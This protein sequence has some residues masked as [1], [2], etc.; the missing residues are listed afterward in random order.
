MS[1]DQNACELRDSFTRLW[2][3]FRRAWMFSVLGGLLV[4]APTFYMSAVY[5]PVVSSRSHVTLLM[6]TLLLVLALAV[7]EVLDW[8]RAETM[9]AAATC[10]DEELTP[11][12][13]DAVYGEGLR[14][15][16]AVPQQPMTDLRTVRDFLCQP[17]LAGVMELPVA[18]VF[19]V[20]L[21][22]LSPVLGWSALIGAMVQ[23]LISWLNHRSTQPPLKEANRASMEA[24]R[25]ADASLK[26]AEVIEAMGMLTDV[27]RRW[28]AKQREFLSKQVEASEA[29]GV[30]Q[31]AS[32]FVQLTLSS[33]LLGVGAWLLLEN[34]LW[35]GGSMLIVG[36]VL[37]GRMLAPLVQLIGQWRTVINAREAWARLSN[38]LS[39]HPVAPPAMPLPPPK[40]M[41]AVEGVTGSPSA[42]SPA[43]LRNVNFALKPGEVL[44]VI[45]P[46]ASGKTTLARLLVGLLPCQ[47]GKVRLDGVDVFAWQKAELGPHVGYLPQGA[48]LLEGTLVENIARFAEAGRAQAEAAAKSVGLHE[49]ILTLPQGYDTRVGKGG[50]VLSGGQRQR[51]ALAR[52]LCGSPALVVLDEPNSSL[53]EAGELALLQ[54]IREQKALGTTFVVMTHKT[55]ILAVVDKMLVLQDGVQQAFGPRDDVLRAMQEASANAKTRAQSVPV[56]GRPPA[57]AIQAGGLP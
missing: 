4:L 16:A 10:L 6:V 42:Q 24:Q 26:H 34:A 43:V 28:F 37:G 18:G 29:G 30:Y 46:S 17:A 50:V 20:I 5:G 44:A 25:Y 3:Y 32:K 9:R 45:G 35:G 33:M 27:H 36:S 53:D 51:V 11:R 7:M 41:L 48:A 21:F 39:Q 22:V 8:A 2:P 12:V 49:F 15:L 47:S 52:A 13:L 19:M 23:T 38:L 31:A 14:R 1:Q 55:G 54:A 57:S 40:G 56:G